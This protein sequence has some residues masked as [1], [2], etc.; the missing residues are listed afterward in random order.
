[1]VIPT[2]RAAACTRLSAT[3]TSSQFNPTKFN[4][5]NRVGQIR[6]P[7]IPTN[8]N[9]SV[10]LKGSVEDV[11]DGI[12][13]EGMGIGHILAS[14]QSSPQT[15]L[16][17]HHKHVHRLAST[18][19]SPW[20]DEGVFRACHRPSWYA[21]ES[22]YQLSR[23]QPQSRRNRGLLVCPALFKGAPQAED[24]INT[25]SARTKATLRRASSQI[26]DSLKSSKEKHCKCFGYHIDEANSPVIRAVSY[27]PRFRNESTS[28]IW[29]YVRVSISGWNFTIG[30]LSSNQDQTLNQ[31]LNGRPL[32]LPPSKRHIPI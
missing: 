2:P 26:T 32:N 27:R 28:P 20:W 24:L 19:G 29:T 5:T 14:R 16:T 31:K 13:K 4:P 6:H 7:D 22:P 12:V 23:K 11:V 21:R 15:S 17:P 3:W 8:L 1:M 9:P 10:V 30:S 25:A 18:G